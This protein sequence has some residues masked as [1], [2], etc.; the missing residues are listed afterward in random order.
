MPLL[1]V[2]ELRERTAE[3]LRQV[4]LDKEEF[5]ITIQGHPVAV[6]LPLD[7]D[8]VEEAWVAVSKQNALSRRGQHP[9]GPAPAP[10]A[11]ATEDGADEA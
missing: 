3:I 6:L 7:T 2:R 9:H 1:G 10:L 11:E 5:V 4:R 8:A